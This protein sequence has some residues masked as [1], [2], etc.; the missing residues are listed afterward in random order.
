MSLM[1]KARQGRANAL[2]AVQ[3][4]QVNVFADLLQVLPR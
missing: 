3:R 2:A 4:L 1:E